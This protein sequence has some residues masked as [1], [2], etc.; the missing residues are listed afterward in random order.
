MTIKYDSVAYGSNV[1]NGKVEY[2]EEYSLN[3]R[4]VF[5]VGI[6]YKAYIE[7]IGGLNK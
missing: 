2:Y 7:A 3:G 5:T 6:T 1:Y 4:I